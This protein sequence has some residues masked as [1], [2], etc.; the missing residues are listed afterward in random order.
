MRRTFTLSL[1]AV[2]VAFGLTL[3][4]NEK[5]T[6]ELQATMKENAA[7]NGALRMHIMEKN[8]E[9]LAKDAQILKTNFGKIEAF[10]TEKKWQ[11]AIDISKAGGKAAGEL[12]AAAVAKDDTAIA[13]AQMALAPN[14]GGCHMKHR[15]QLPDKSYEI[16]P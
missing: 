15:E 14:C 16:K 7:T 4:A 10:F 1:L 6:P 5:P 11:D 3:F 9:A 2:T 13:A 8:Y 12:Q